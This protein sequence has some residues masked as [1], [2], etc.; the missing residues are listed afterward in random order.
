MRLILIGP[1]GAGKGTQAQRLTSYLGAPHISTGDLL[2]EAVAMGTSQGLQAKRHLEQGSLAPDALIVEM[3]NERLEQEDCSGGCLL[4]GFP[5]TVEQAKAL[6][7]LLARRCEPLDGVIALMVDDET[8]LE[9]LLGRGRE[10]DIPTIIKERFQAYRRLTQPVLDY[11]RRRG[12]LETVDG[13]GAPDQV[14]ARVRAV[15]DRI[16]SKQ[17][18]GDAN[19]S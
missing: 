2:R 13:V 5:R 8:L 3:I 18:T 16:R 15:L 19:S 17:Q 10:D 9:R 14:F 1:P 11:Y 6:D 4:D 7:E 12:I